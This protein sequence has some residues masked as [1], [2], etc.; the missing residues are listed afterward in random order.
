MNRLYFTG[1]VSLATA[2]IDI[3]SAASTPSGSAFPSADIAL[4]VASQ[5][6]YDYYDMSAGSL[7][8][9]GIS[10][11]VTDISY[12]NSEEMYTYPLNYSDMHID[13][14]AASFTTG[15]FNWNRTGDVVSSVDTYGTLITPAGTFTDILRVFV[16]QD[17]EDD[18]IGSPQVSEYEVEV[19]H[20]YKAGI[21]YPVM[22]STWIIANFQL[23]S[24]IQYTEIPAGTGIN[25]SNFIDV[26]VYPNPTTDVLNVI[27]DEFK[28]ATYE[29]MNAL[30]QTVSAG[31]LTA[32][33]VDV[34]ELNIGMYVLK[35]TTT[36]GESGVSR[37]QVN[38]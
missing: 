33:K 14:F 1:L 30:G 19:Y 3:V 38:R 32:G 12:T 18:P 37:F 6:S 27:G 9:Y 35:A 2:D 26:A 25:E 22:V 34:S 29:V 13:D 21:H 8:H 20:Y 5:G 4:H 17:Y 7:T 16:Q 11:S 10:Y 31:I 15:G 23:Q 36:S 28:N 24:S